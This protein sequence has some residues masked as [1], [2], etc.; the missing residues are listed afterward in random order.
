VAR[1]GKRVKRLESQIKPV[2]DTRADSACQRA[3]H[4]HFIAV[5]NARLEMQ[6]LP[7]T[8][9]TSEERAWQRELDRWFLAEGM[10]AMRADPGWQDSESQALL[11]EWEKS[12]A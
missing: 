1:L 9:L 3:L 11:D 2:A 5:E 7:P 4:L 8:P 6:G 12:L 10:P